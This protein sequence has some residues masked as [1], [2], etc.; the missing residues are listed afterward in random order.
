MIREGSYRYASRKHKKSTNTYTQLTAM[1][2]HKIADRCDER[3]SNEDDKQKTSKLPECIRTDNM[4]TQPLVTR[5]VTKKQM[6]LNRRVEAASKTHTRIHA[7]ANVD[8]VGKKHPRGTDWMEYI[9]GWNL[10]GS[11][12]HRQEKSTLERSRNQKT[13]T[14]WT[15]TA[16]MLQQIAMNR[17]GFMNRS[18][19]S[20]IASRPNAKNSYKKE[21][22]CN[23]D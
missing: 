11:A 21:V 1:D 19:G 23:S 15:T 4:M 22:M 14:V 17:N 10:K 5:N 8:N 3:R 20:T 7:K 2:I 18:R 16:N 9:G 13:Y 6:S 12:S